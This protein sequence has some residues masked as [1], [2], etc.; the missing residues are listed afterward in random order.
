VGI[1]IHQLIEIKRMNDLLN[2]NEQKVLDLLTA[3]AVGT[4]PSADGDVRFGYVDDSD[5]KDVD[6]SPQSF[7]AYVTIL[8]IKEVLNVF[9]EDNDV[10]YQILI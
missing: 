9:N 5:P 10:E 7:G 4:A 8:Q 1:L 6:M 3:N 2:A